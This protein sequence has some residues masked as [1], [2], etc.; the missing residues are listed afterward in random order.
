MSKDTACNLGCQDYGDKCRDQH[1]DGFRCTRPKGHSGDHVACGELVH[2]VKSWPNVEDSIKIWRDIDAE[3]QATAMCDLD[4]QDLLRMVLA[5]ANR[6]VH[7]CPKYETCEKQSMMTPRDHMACI[8]CMVEWAR[9]EAGR[10]R[11]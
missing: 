4:H 1:Y 9:K 11:G 6:A 3:N 5:L 8:D 10:V 2:N 7:A